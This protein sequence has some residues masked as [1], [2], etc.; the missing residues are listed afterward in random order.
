MTWLFLLLAAA[1]LLPVLAVRMIFLAPTPAGWINYLANIFSEF[2]VKKIGWSRLAVEAAMAVAG[3]VFLRI[4]GLDWTVVLAMALLLAGSELYIRIASQRLLTECYAREDPIGLRAAGNIAIT[5]GLA[6][7]YPGPS[8]HPALTV[9]LIGPFVERMPRYQLGTLLVG[10]VFTLRLVIG[11]HTIVPTQTGVRLRT[12]APPG[13]SLEHPEEQMLPRLAPADVHE[14]RQTWR[15]ENAA[16]AGTIGFAIEWGHLSERIE[17]EFDGCVAAGQLAIERVAIERYSGACR[18]AFAWRGD[19]DLYDES[20]LQSIEGL[21]VTL[22]LAARYRIPQSMYLSTRLSLDETAAMQWAAHYGVD[23]GAARIPAF[24][25]WIRQNVDLRHEC[26]YPFQSAKAFAI[27]LGN[28][29]HLHYGTDTSGAEENGWKRTK[30]G[31]GAYPWL[32]EDRSSFAEQRD[33]ALEVRRLFEQHFAYTPRS[34]AMPNRT[35]DSHTAAAMEAAGCEVLSDSNIRTQHNVLLQPPPHHPTGT[36][37]VEL[38]KRYPGDPQHIFHVAMNSFWIH[39]AHRLG[40]PVVFMCHQHLRQFAGYACARFTEATLR[41]VLSR[42]HG[43]LHVNTVFGIGKYWREVLSPRTKRV[44]VELAGEQ[45]RVSNKSDFD[46]V[47]APVD[48][49]LSKNRRCTYLID[50]PAGEERSLPVA[51]S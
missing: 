17:V 7:G 35:N 19:M 22:G 41:D 3:L 30:I 11:N 43:D 9:N 47:D 20:T 13:L 16:G 31:G 23:R 1:C 51:T 26:A 8:T 4:A 36:S 39:R 32:G 42:F 12:T 6:A 24:I 45:M 34:W 46:L 40:I 27:E 10:R 18:S 49:W 50:V 21:E 29:G 14:V 44:H 33:N 2:F 28:H 37:A 25:E 15:V 38:T 5:K 48:I